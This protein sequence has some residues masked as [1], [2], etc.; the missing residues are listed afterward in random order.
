MAVLAK[1]VISFITN[2]ILTVLFIIFAIWIATQTWSSFNEFFGVKD[3][4]IV[5]EMIEAA[6]KKETGILV[7]LTP[8]TPEFVAP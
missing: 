4:N 5:E 8:D 1:L 3:D 7:D 6:I 2:R